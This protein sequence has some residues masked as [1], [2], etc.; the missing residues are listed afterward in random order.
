MRLRTRASRRRSRSR[1]LRRSIRSCRALLSRSTDGAADFCLRLDAPRGVSPAFQSILVHEAASEDDLLGR[2]RCFCDLSRG[3]AAIASS[4]CRRG[5]WRAHHRGFGMIDA[6]PGG[7]AWSLNLM[8]HR[9]MQRLSS[10]QIFVLD[11]SRWVEA[12]GRPAHR[13]RAW[14][15]G[16]VVFQGARS[17]R[18]RATSRRRARG[19]A[20]QARKLLVLDLDD[21]LWGGIVGDAGSE[22]LRLGGHDPDGRGVRRLPAGGSSSSR[23]AA[24]CSASSA[25]TPRRGAAGDRTATRRWCSEQTTSSRWRINWGDKARNIADHG[26]RS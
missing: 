1:T 8:N 13:R 6:R 26:R 12:A 16:K 22:N 4:S 23:D 18:R 3:R 5:R 17:P 25:R 2:S 7:A 15:M 19:I 14:Y 24:S 9:L 21:T 11:A 20:G 10:S